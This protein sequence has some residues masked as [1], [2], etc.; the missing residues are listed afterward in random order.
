MKH[1]DML[2]IMGKIVTVSATFQKAWH[3]HNR[4]WE[5]VNIHERSGWIIGVRTIYDAYFRRGLMG[6]T[7][8]D[9]I[10]TTENDSVATTHP[11]QSLL[12]AF[13]PDENPIHVPPDAISLE[14]H[15]VPY[16]S[17]AAAT[18]KSW[19]DDAK[20]EQSQIMSDRPR[21]EKGHWLKPHSAAYIAWLHN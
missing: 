17:R 14:V 15:H 16:S 12:V 13:W 9:R 4:V 8:N 6:T 10:A 2:Q 5:R 7:E 19:T 3:G 21:D 1:K 18:R 20:R 11:Q